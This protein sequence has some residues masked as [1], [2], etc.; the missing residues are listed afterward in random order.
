MDFE[1][2]EEHKILREVIRDFNEGTEAF[3]EKR[4]PVY[5]TK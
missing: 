4:K 3:V 5:E 2:S 1:F